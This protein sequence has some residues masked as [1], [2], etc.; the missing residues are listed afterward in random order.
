[1]ISGTSVTRVGSIPHRSTSID[2]TAGPAASQWSTEAAAC[3]RREPEGRT[4]SATP[5]SSWTITTRRPQRPAVPSRPARVLTT[6]TS[7]S[8][9]D[10]R[11]ERDTRWEAPSVTRDDANPSM[12]SGTRRANRRNPPATDVGPN[13]SNSSRRG[14]PPRR[15]VDV[16]TAETECFIHLRNSSNDAGA[17]VLDASCPMNRTEETLTP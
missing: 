3:V 7:T 2:R 16:S 17:P 11:A 5:S 6:S 15:T 8:S 12:R 13:A 1:M 14:P 10:H 4:R 9:L